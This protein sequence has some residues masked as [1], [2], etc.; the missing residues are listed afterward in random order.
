METVM[1]TREDV[2]YYFDTHIMV[3]SSFKAF[4]VET[5]TQWGN[6]PTRHM[7]GDFFQRGGYCILGEK[8]RV[9]QYG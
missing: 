4:S 6:C 1:T 3:F 8:D 7:A 9:T 2:N 5:V